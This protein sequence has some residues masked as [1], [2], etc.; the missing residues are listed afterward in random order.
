MDIILLIIGILFLIKGADAFVDGASSIANNLKIP[1]IIVGLTIVSFGTSAPEAAVSVT[2]A[3]A[4]SNEIAVSNVLG[5]N[6]FNILCV[7]GCTALIAKMHVQE[8]IVKSEFPIM[9]VASAVMVAFCL[10]GRMVTRLEGIIL[11]ICILLYVLRLVLQALKQRDQLEVEPAKYTTGKSVLFCIIGIAAIVLGGQLVVNSASN[12][13][14]A[15]GVSETMV[16]LTIVS[17]G[18][19][20]PELVTSVI[21]AKKGEVD[22]ALG[23]VIGSNIFNI[24]FILGLSSTVSPIPVSAMIDIDLFIMMASCLLVY[25]IAYW[26]RSFV[27]QSGLIMVAI[28]IAYMIFVIIRA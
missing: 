8:N 9:L 20:L 16:G 25:G 7:V 15:L 17:I 10:T 6:L 4:H 3:L 24:L 27:W 11:L 22:I 18:T 14:L 23:N 12:L 26:K 13:A 28:N 19:S 5:S 21:A 2:A 1:A